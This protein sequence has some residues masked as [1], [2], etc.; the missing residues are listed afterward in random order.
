MSTRLRAAS[1]FGKIHFDG[2]CGRR[3]TERR[4][5][6]RI[7]L[8][9]A[10]LRKEVSR[11]PKRPSLPAAPERGGAGHEEEPE[12]EDVH[13]SDDEHLDERKEDARCDQAEAGAEEDLG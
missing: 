12:E 2:K 5:R 7:E 11:R 13:A 10:R 9:T 3:S 6:P 1:T 8:E 4:T